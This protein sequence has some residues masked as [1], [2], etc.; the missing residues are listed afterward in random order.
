MGKKLIIEFQIKYNDPVSKQS[1]LSPLSANKPP[2]FTSPPPPICSTLWRAAKASPTCPNRTRLQIRFCPHPVLR[3]DR[4]KQLILHVNKDR[5]KGKKKEPSKI[6]PQLGQAREAQHSQG[7]NGWG[8]GQLSPAQPLFGKT[9]FN[10][11]WCQARATLSRTFT[12]PPCAPGVRRYII[13]CSRAAWGTSP[14]VVLSQGDPPHS[15]LGASTQL[16][17]PRREGVGG[18]EGP[19]ASSWKFR[20]EQGWWKPSK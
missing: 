16:A 15:T 7:W 8:T 3:K 6:P 9:K 17:P 4:V 12:H 18:W 19:R 5:C 14:H 13:T 1:A 2:N 11:T 20:P 10:A